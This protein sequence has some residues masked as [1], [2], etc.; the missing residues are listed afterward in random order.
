MIIQ[1]ILEHQLHFRACPSLGQESWTFIFLY[2]VPVESRREN[3]KIPD[4]FQLFCSCEQIASIGQRQLH[5]QIS[6][7]H[8]NGDSWTVLKW[9][10]QEEHCLIHRFNK[11]LMK[12]CTL[13]DLS[14]L[15]TGDRAMNNG[16][17]SLSIWNLHSKELHDLQWIKLK[18]QDL[19]KRK[20]SN[21]GNTAC[22]SRIREN[23]YHYM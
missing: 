2:S 9:S 23:L 21:I 3:V 10:A 17:K 20:V 7:A 14:L 19:N 4:S 13:A 1:K 8:R 16:Q 12:A 6:K 22:K 5:V 18:N 11:R 15:G